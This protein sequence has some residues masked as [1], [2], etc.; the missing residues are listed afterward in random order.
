MF[1]TIVRLAAQIHRRRCTTPRAIGAENIRR[2][3][4]SA[5]RAFCKQTPMAV[6][7]HRRLCLRSPGGARGRPSLSAVCNT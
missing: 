2:D 1:A 5:S 4:F 3:I 7:L 6:M